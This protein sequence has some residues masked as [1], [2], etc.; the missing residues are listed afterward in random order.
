VLQIPEGQ[1]IDIRQCLLA[2]VTDDMNPHSCSSNSSTS[3]N[4]NN[5]SNGESSQ[6]DPVSKVE[7]VCEKACMVLMEYADLLKTYFKIGIQITDCSLYCLPDL[8][9]GYLP[10]QSFLPRFLFQ[11]A[12][13]LYAL[14]K[15]NDECDEKDENGVS[16]GNS[17]S[18]S[19][20]IA[21]QQTDVVVVVSN[22][23]YGVSNTGTSVTE[24]KELT[25]DVLEAVTTELSVYFA[26]LPTQPMNEISNNNSNNSYNNK[27]TTVGN[28]LTEEG[29]NYLTHII[30]PTIKASLLPD[31]SLTDQKVF[32]PIATLE[33]LYKVFER[34]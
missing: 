1:Y 33:K 32:I 12:A 16:N 13:R 18:S 14:K 31:S 15:K 9:P 21:S 11:L 30:Y 26:R 25:E 3:V 2:V 24:K 5:S 22:G 8:L 27:T 6:I 20:D 28:K 19:S 17:N 29:E 10:D 34:C 7:I 4:V 23:I